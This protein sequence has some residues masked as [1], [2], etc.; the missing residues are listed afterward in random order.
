MDRFFIQNSVELWG[1]AI[2]VY[3]LLSII[4]KSIFPVLGFLL[5][6]G[7]ILGKGYFQNSFIT[8]G[9]QNLLYIYIG[10][11][12]LVGFS[13]I[14]KVFR[15]NYLA[16][17]DEIT[18]I[19]YGVFILV[20]FALFLYFQFYVSNLD[21][22][23]SY[24]IPSILMGLILMVIWSKTE[25]FFKKHEFSYLIDLQKEIQKKRKIYYY[26]FFGSE[27]LDEIKKIADG[28]LAKDEISQFDYLSNLALIYFDH[29]EYEKS[30][31][32]FNKREELLVSGV[33]ENENPSLEV[34][35]KI[36]KTLYFLGMIKERTNDENGAL[37][38]YEM[39]NKLS[40][41]KIY[42]VKNRIA[43][44]TK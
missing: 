15:N 36:A 21:E 20:P 5:Y 32:Y 14:T 22:T 4:K 9:F 28:A 24:L 33:P 17:R 11:F 12:F 37:E 1:T 41:G 26:T 6:A 3:I 10:I 8:D 31:K 42:F 18:L 25:Y 34:L 38:H 39:A 2:A 19:L 40:Q 44:L 27:D 16:H 30:E 7:L 13:F 29:E 43:E 35:E 23:L